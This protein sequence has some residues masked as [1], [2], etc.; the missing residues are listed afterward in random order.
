MKYAL[1]IYR[2]EAAA[3][4]ASEKQMGEMMAAYGAYTKAMRDSGAFVA[5]DPVQSSATASTVRIVDGRTKVLNGPYADTKEQLGGYY[6]IEAANNEAAQ[7]WAARCPGA[8]GGIIEVR[9]IMA[10]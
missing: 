4:G 3:K 2:N 8:Q 1:L 9:P 5:G 6:I 10:Y 7:A